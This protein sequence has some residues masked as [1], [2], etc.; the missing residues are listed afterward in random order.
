MPNFRQRKWL[1]AAI[2]IAIVLLLT[3]VAAPSGDKNNDGSTYGRDPA[4]YGAW[5]EYMVDKERA[6]ERW[7]KPFAEFIQDDRENTV[8]LR[9]VTG[10][11]YQLSSPNLSEAERDWIKKGNTLIVLG[12]N[13]PATAAPFRS[14]LTHRESTLSSSQIEIETTRRYRSRKEENSL[15]SDRFG[16]VVWSEKIGKGKVI[17]STTPYLAANAYQDSPDNYEFLARLIESDRTVYVDEYIHGYKDKETIA[18]EEKGG[19]L[20]YLAQTPWYLLFIQLVIIASIATASAFRRFGQP[21]AVK[22]A[23]VDNSTA[24]IDALAGVLEKANSTD[25]VVDTIGKDE[26]RKLQT[27][28]GLGKSLV[29][30]DTLVAAWKQQKTKSAELSQ[31]LQVRDAN[32]EISDAKLITWIE[33]WQKINQD[34]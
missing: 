34:N 8:Y 17:Y 1:L 6:I 21:V 19:I 27:S 12:V 23:I 5:Y 10:I 28:L 3:L 30:N 20:A 2:A 24:Y 31:L 16:V 33:Q 22:D 9:V 29:D 25:F 11:N 7:R 32:Q 4:G 26:Q 18:E 14:F 15:L 13:Q